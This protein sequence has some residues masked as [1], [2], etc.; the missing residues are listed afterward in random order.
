ML[1]NPI[2]R[3]DLIRLVQALDDIQLEED[4]RILLMA[5]LVLSADR[6][7]EPTYRS[8]I[9]PST[10]RPVR[11]VVKQRRTLPSIDQLF[12]PPQP[13]EIAEATEEDDEPTEQEQGTD[14][15]VV[16]LGIGR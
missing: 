5:V 3:D 9:D 16:T 8:K 4:Q 2:G 7:G 1:E 12:Q 6:I 11:L 15:V 13:G 10:E 14:V